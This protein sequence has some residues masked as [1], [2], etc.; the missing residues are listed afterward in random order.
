[1][2]LVMRFTHSVSANNMTIVSDALPLSSVPGSVRAMVEM[3]PSESVSVN[4]DFKLAVSRD[5]GITFTD[6]VLEPYFGNFYQAVIDVSGQPAGNDLRLRFQ[7]LNNKNVGA[8][9]WFA[10]VL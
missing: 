3:F 7:S 4:V 1:M 10:Q 5:D 8:S 6:A 9:G 2:H